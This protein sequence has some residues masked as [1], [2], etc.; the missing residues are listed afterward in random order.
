MVATSIVNE[1]NK[2]AVLLSMFHV[3]IYNDYARGYNY[4]L[5]KIPARNVTTSQLVQEQGPDSKHN[6]V[7]CLYSIPTMKGRLANKVVNNIK[8]AVTRSMAAGTSSQII[9]LTLYI[10]CK[11]SIYPNRTV[12]NQM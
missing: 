2:A 3:I 10:R 4:V 9:M 1:T 6:A 11:S 5:K 8:L 7:M 12:S